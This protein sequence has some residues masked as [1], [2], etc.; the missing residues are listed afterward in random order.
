MRPRHGR[1][2]ANALIEAAMLLPL[3]TYFFMG[4]V[5]F[6][7]IGYTYYTLQKIMYN[8]ARFVS[9]RSALDFCADGDTQL[10]Q[11]RN[12]AVTGTTDNSTEPL[13]PDLRPDSF[14][15]RIERV[16]PE[17]GELT[18]CECSNAG[19]CDLTN[20]GRGP[21]FVAVRLSD[22]YPVVIRIPFLGSDPIIL[23]PQARVPYGGS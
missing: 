19:G 16:E 1:R 14:Q 21:D 3:L 17:S 23:R 8:F 6:A 12:F 7:R 15:V 11:A 2:K 18:E 13:L 20:G 5:E 22:G 4:T 9:T 10:T